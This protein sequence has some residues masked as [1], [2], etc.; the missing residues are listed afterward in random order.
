[1]IDASMRLRVFRIV[2]SKCSTEGEKER[3]RS[4]R[5]GRGREWGKLCT[6]AELAPLLLVGSPLVDVGLHGLELCRL[7]RRNGRQLVLLLVA[8]DVLVPPLV[9]LVPRPGSLVLLCA[10]PTLP[11]VLGHR[12]LEPVLLELLHLFFELLPTL[13]VGQEL[14]T[15]PAA[16]TTPATATASVSI[17]APGAVLFE[18]HRRE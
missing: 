2:M 3:K 16:A 9:V 5:R 1:M 7:R 8:I 11:P 17:P 18:L 14:D 4:G 13:L 10:L 15:L 12:L 6:V